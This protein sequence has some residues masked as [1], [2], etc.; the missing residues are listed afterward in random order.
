MT[1]PGLDSA[2]QRYNEIPDWSIRN[3]NS[4]LDVGASDGSM[5]KFSRYGSIFDRVNDAGDYLGLDIQEF[6]YSYYNIIKRDL[7]DFVA[8]R[9]YDLVLASHVIE[10]IELEE[11][12]RIF[13]ELFGCVSKGGYL[14][15]MVP[16][17]QSETGY[18]CECSPM[19]HKVFDID[20]IMLE[21][22]LPGGQYLYSRC[23]WRHFRDKG[24]FFPYALFR[25]VF[26]ALTFHPYSVFNQKGLI[27]QIVGVWRKRFE[28]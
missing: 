2:V 17:K 12:P 1:V 27:S 19:R 24:E 7:R 13:D 11:W 28:E 8:V 4:V 22:F 16:F 26:R 5:A 20:K 6:D 3:A 21:S 18:T 15:V 23:G 14:V 9:H 10:H 25:F